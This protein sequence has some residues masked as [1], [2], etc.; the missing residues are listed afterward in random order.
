MIIWQNTAPDIASV[1][2]AERVVEF[3]VP[4]HLGQMPL[5]TAMS[6]LSSLWRTLAMCCFLAALS[7][8]LWACRKLDMFR[9]W[10]WVRTLFLN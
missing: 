9:V 1:V 10:L 6:R 4:P 3:R 7:S 5:E 8:T 2:R